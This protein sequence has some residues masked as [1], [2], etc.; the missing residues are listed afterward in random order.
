MINMLKKTRKKNVGKIITYALI[1]QTYGKHANGYDMR[2]NLSVSWDTIGKYATDLFTENAVEMINNHNQSIPMFLMVSHLAPHTGN[3]YELMQAPKE[4]IKKFN[5]IR[6][7]DRRTYAA[8]VSKL[9]ESVG[10]IVDAL[11][12][13]EMLENSIIL[14]MS[15]NGAPIKGTLSHYIQTPFK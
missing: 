12:K 6:N 15:D 10:K 11:G 14:F 13:N 9:D 3:D 7:R 8:M 2:K 5:Y 1:L 4:E